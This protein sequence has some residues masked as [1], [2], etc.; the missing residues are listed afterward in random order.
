[1]STY[2]ARVLSAL[3]SF[4]AA[5]AGCAAALAA[6]AP[7]LP[8]P[9]RDRMASEVRRAADATAKLRVSL[10]LTERTGADIVDM[11]VRIQGETALLAGA[12]HAVGEVAGRLQGREDREQVTL[13]PG[14]VKDAL[15][16]L[17]ERAQLVAAALFPNAVDGLRP[18]NVK[19]WDFDKLLWKRYTDLLTRLVQNGELTPAQQA[20]IQEV[21][22]GIRDGFARVNDLLNRLATDAFT[23]A[24]AVRRDIA[25]ARHTMKTH[26]HAARARMTKS[27]EAFKPMV[28][29]AADIAAGVDGLLAKL[30]IPIFPPFA[31]LPI[32]GAIDQTTYEGLSGVQR[33]ALLNVA[34]RMQQTTVAGQPLWSAAYGIAVTNV[35]PDRIYLQADA[36]LIESVKNDAGQFKSAPA[37]LHRFREGSFKQKTFGKGN[38]QLC[39]Q[40]DGRRV[41]LDA[42]IDLFASAI[43]HLF[44]EVLVNHLT[45]KTTDQFS[46]RRILDAQGVPPM[47]GFSI[48]TPL[49]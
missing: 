15:G 37:S 45:G 29:K 41:N 9:E 31:A 13:L 3:D 38:L 21:A 44:G 25:A 48:L 8:A 46:V 40:T 33:F 27:V 7:P 19:L 5:V 11:Q 2:G 10:G 23:D 14:A 36:R 1:M 35:F 4:D 18:I 34:A 12:L 39:Y 42:D 47:A 17:D 26:L 24:D 32:A 43:R 28:E 20:R 16:G 49:V 22:H 30:Q 6:P